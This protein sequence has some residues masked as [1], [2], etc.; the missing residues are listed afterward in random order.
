M[1]IHI[2]LLVFIFLTLLSGCSEKNSKTAQNH[3]VAN[4]VTTTKDASSVNGNQKVFPTNQLKQDNK[5]ADTFINLSDIEYVTMQGGLHIHTKAL[6]PRHDDQKIS[7]IVALINAG[8][9]KIISTKTE[10]SVINSEARPIGI[11]FGL[12][13]GSKIYAWTDYTTKSFKDGWSASTLDDRFVLNIQKD[14]LDEYYTIFSRDVAKYLK[15]SWKDDMPIVK[16]VDVKSEFS[17]GGDNVV[18]RGGDKAVVTGDGCTAKEVIIRVM[19]NGKPKEVYDVGKVT[20]QYGQWEWKGIIS[21]QCKTIDG[22][23]V[24]LANDLYD[25]IADADGNQTGAS[26]VI[27][28]RDT[29]EAK[30]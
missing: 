29:K 21:R 24:T 4:T 27:Y 6:F 8:T 2:V 14:G 17:A 23:T 1:K 18:L 30:N 28:L 20:P 11:H 7:K 16:E 9:G 25:I 12:K 5:N 10:I 3:S 15:E 26:C 22:K 13:D 19:R